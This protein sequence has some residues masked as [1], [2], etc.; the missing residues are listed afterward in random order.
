MVISTL[1]FEGPLRLTFQMTSVCPDSEFAPFESFETPG[2]WEC[3]G[4]RCLRMSWADIWSCQRLPQSLPR[5][6]G[7]GWELG[8][9]GRVGKATTSG[10]HW[11]LCRQNQPQKQTPPEKAWTA[12]V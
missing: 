12:I 1:T 10:T 3:L 4:L 5:D 6:K 8:E 11:G 7:M 9:A 2:A